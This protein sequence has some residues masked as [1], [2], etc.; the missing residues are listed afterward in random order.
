MMLQLLFL[1]I[2]LLF[3]SIVLISLHIS[4]LDLREGVVLGSIQIGTKVHFQRFYFKMGLSFL[5]NDF[6]FLVHELK[7]NTQNY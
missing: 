4:L 3:V 7:K 5:V 1:L 2:I 6:R